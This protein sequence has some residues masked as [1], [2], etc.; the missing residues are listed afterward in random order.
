MTAAVAQAKVL[1]ETA[2][3]VRDEAAR[4]RDFARVIRTDSLVLRVRTR[5]TRGARR[6]CGGSTPDIR[7]ITSLIHE[8]AL[9]VT[10]IGYKIGVPRKRVDM[11]LKEIGRTV[12]LRTAVANCHACLKQT[13]VYGLK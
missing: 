12:A 2:E 9:C 3:A 1:I 7:E 13:V 5:E 11:A 6:I 10:C 8:V 4:M